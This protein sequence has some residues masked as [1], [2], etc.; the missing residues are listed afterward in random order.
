MPPSLQSIVPEVNTVKADQFETKFVLFTSYELHAYSGCYWD[1]APREAEFKRAWWSP[2]LGNTSRN[3]QRLVTTL[4]LL[5]IPIMYRN[6][7]FSRRRRLT[8]QYFFAFT[9]LQYR[10]T[11]TD[12]I[13]KYRNIIPRGRRGGIF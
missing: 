2:R 12:S 4:M 13:P 9:A 5:P 1:S 7:Y 3:L 11:G 6:L 10:N 8:E